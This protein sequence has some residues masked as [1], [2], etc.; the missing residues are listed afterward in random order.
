MHA[1]V[2]PSDTNL[3]E[4]ELRVRPSASL[5]RSTI[6]VGDEVQKLHCLDHIGI[7]VL[8]MWCRL[9]FEPACF[10]FCPYRKVAV[11]QFA[12]RKARHISDL[13]IY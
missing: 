13:D 2:A 11:R 4:D 3:L 6:Y 7:Y 1:L 5:S 12:V 8:V 10:A 9:D